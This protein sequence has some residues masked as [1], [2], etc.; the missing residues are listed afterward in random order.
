M[1]WE[2][3]KTLVSSLNNNNSLFND[4]QLQLLV[5]HFL[6]RKEVPDN[7]LP[8]FVDLPA[9][10]RNHMFTPDVANIV[11]ILDE[12]SSSE[13]LPFWTS[14][15]AKSVGELAVE[16]VDYYALFDPLMTAISIQHGLTNKKQDAATLKARP[17]LNVY[18][19]FH[20]SSVC[21]YIFC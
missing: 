6:S 17:K 16:L 9:Q 18:D 21:S 5:L 10:M 19:P 13:R 8:A 11:R 14:K 4:Y 2:F 1:S 12:P 7:V 15:S 20:P 3:F